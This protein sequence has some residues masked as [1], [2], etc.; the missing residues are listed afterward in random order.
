LRA[1]KGGG[2][3]SNSGGVMLDPLQIHVKNAAVFMHK[4]EHSNKQAAA[5]YILMCV[6][7]HEGVWICSKS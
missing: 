3:R 5:V 1:E 7:L 4:C 6:N 2:G